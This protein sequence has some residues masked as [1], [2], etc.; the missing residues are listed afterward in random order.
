MKS[1]KIQ[2]GPYLKIVLVLAKLRTA[3][4]TIPIP[5]SSDAFNCK[6]RVK[7]I[8]KIIIS[9]I[10]LRIIVLRVKSKGKSDEREQILQSAFDPFSNTLVSRKTNV[11]HLQINIEL[12]LIAVKSQ[13]HLSV[14][15]EAK[16]YFKI[17]KSCLS[18]LHCCLILYLFR[19]Q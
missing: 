15:S 4:R 2:I 1:Q 14:C 11:F 8:L 18:I 9:I 16:L 3:P 5:R 6:S 17:K 19:Y 13:F 7:K 10:I 12:F